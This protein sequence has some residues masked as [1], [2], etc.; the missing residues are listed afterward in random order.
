MSPHGISYTLQQSSRARRLTIR[1][2]SKGQVIV[3]T[4]PRFPKYKVSE[5]VESAR[6]WIEKQLVSQ[7]KKPVLL[8]ST[9]VF[10]F[11]KEYDVKVSKRLDGTVK[12]GKEVV[13]VSPLTLTSAA[14]LTLLSGWL[15]SRAIEYIS[16]R[17]YELGDTMGL[18]FNNLVFKQQKTRWGSCSSQKNLNFNWKLIHAP[19]EVIDYVIIHELAHLTHMNHGKHFWNLVVK[20]DPDHPHHRRWLERFGGTES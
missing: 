15:K 11:G 20:Y 6:A 2:D 17:V 3:T 12:V 14:V 19:K 4:P 16:K 13:I 9:K 8:S 7:V 18:K 10:Y 5:F 1:V